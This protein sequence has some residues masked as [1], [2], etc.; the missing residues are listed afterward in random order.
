MPTPIAPVA[1][2]TSI[3][4][5]W[6][7]SVA[8]GVNELQGDLYVS[9]QLTIP[10]DTVSGKPTAF[11]PSAHAH[12]GPGSGGTVAWAAITGKPTAFA[13]AD[14]APTH[15]TGGTDVLKAS[16]IGGFDR[17][18]SGGTIGTKQFVGP[19]EPTTGVVEGDVWIKG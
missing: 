15:R 1:P 6:G 13:P 3:T 12:D 7:N 9:G 16:E 19:T 10:W 5:A 11:V 18:A 17:V 8:T 14:H 2:A 4:S